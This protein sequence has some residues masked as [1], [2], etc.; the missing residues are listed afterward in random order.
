MLKNIDNSFQAYVSS[1]SDGETTSELKLRLVE[2]YVDLIEKHILQPFSICYPTVSG[3][4]VNQ[5][6]S[7]TGPLTPSTPSSRPLKACIVVVTH[8][9]PILQ[10]LKHFQYDLNFS[11]PGKV[12]HP[13]AF[14]KGTSLYE[15]QLERRY[16]TK[17]QEFDWKG[18]IH[19][20]NCV[21][22]LAGLE[23]YSISPDVPPISK[24]DQSQSFTLV[25]KKKD[26]KIENS[27][28]P[29]FSPQLEEL[30]FGKRNKSLGW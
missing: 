14:P 28:L 16:S 4:R 3:T 29:N 11:M 30:S 5:L 15:I 27:M 22:H 6:I 23:N 18:S 2:F 7:N 19:L 13:Y 8:G 12:S 26:K 21:S 10:L 9:G 17:N 20:I 1:Q 24:T 25:K